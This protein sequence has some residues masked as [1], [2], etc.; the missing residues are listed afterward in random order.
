M[1][2]GDYAAPT[3]PYDS[4]R[5]TRLLG[6]E[7][8]GR[9]ALGANYLTSAGGQ[10]S[11]SLPALDYRLLP[12]DS[13]LGREAWAYLMSRGVTPDQVATH[14]IGLGRGRLVGRVVLPVVEGGAMVY[15]VARSFVGRE[16]KYL[17]AANGEMLRTA[18]EVLFGLG[19]AE[20][21][22]RVTLVEGYFDALAEAP[23]GVATFGSALSDAQVDLLAAAC[24][25]RPLDVVVKRDGD[26]TVS[27][28][29]MFAMARQCAAAGARSVRVDVP[30][31]DPADRL[32]LASSAPYSLRALVAAR[33][34][35]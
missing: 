29:A 20:L 35:E 23:V 15:Y 30:V 10:S 26:G 6:H 18:S 13:V 3:A 34:G 7:K 28:A 8:G 33:V 22:G 4:E 5:L 32:G 11:G 1:A 17:N 16:P 21:Y 24:R 31:G 12:H 9:H 14:R 2:G 19:V 27:R 25:R